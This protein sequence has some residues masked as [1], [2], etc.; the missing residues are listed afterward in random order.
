MIIIK[1]NL[2]YDYINFNIMM[3]YYKNY[4]L[5]NNIKFSILEKENEYFIINNNKT[6]NNRGIINDIV[7]YEDNEL[8]N[9]KE[10]SK[11]KIIGII[12]IC[13]KTKFVNKNKTYYLFKPIN[14]QFPNFYVSTKVK[15]NNK[16]YCLIDFLEWNINS[17]YPYGNLIEILGNVGDINSDYK[18]LLYLNNIFSK[19]LNFDKTKIKK[20]EILINNIKEY[21]YKIFTIDPKNS[22]DLDDGFHFIEKDNFYELGIHISNPSKLLFDETNNIINKVS[23]I[24]LNNNL[25]M[26]PKIYSENFCSLLE[27]TNKYC[28]S[29]IITFDKDNNIINNEFKESVVF[30]NKNYDYDEFDKVYKKSNNLVKIINLTKVFFNLHEID[31]HIFVEK[32]MIYY[33]MKIIDYFKNKNLL[34]NLIIRSHKKRDFTEEI[35]DIELKKYLEIKNKN[36]AIYKLFDENDEDNIHSE[37][38]N[39]YTHFT[40]PLRRC[41]DF[42]LN[43]Y[44]INEKEIF[45]KNNLINKVNY[46]NDYEKRIKKFYKMKNRF[47]FL[48]KNE[49]EEIF[50]YG[51]IVKIKENKLKIYLPELNLE[52]EYILFNRKTEKISNVVYEKKDNIIC[53][54]EYLFDNNKITYN[55]YQKINCKLYIFLKEDNFYDKIKI[56]ILET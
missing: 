35:N 31:S 19:N 28:I 6:I 56:S 4:K 22:K 8:I 2:I 20:H 9:I 18:S 17:Q 29:F 51:Y 11:Q 39:L 48:H 36:K 32:W 47:D 12:N 45:D 52:E 24:Y 34:N 26:I 5:E 33:N 16:I 7:Y 41:V 3:N 55:L 54:L 30:I 53:N 27:N 46:I 10:R 40:S 49:K 13:S 37:M 43:Y 1:Y 25:N 50:S 23:T 42:L 44:F 21:D 15:N 38:N 14:K